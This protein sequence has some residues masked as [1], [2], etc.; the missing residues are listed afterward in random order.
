M[1]CLGMPT[2]YQTLS[3]PKRM[4]EDIVEFIINNPRLGYTSAPE[5]VK[6]AIRK[7][8]GVTELSKTTATL[9]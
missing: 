5:F 2:G 6:D 4:Y 8:L 9:S 1:N 7:N 3:I